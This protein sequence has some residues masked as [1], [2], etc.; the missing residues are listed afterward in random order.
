VND[1]A[2]RNDQF[3]HKLSVD[4]DNGA[5]GIVYY[6]TGTGADRKKT[7]VLFQAS[8]DGGK[9]WSK[10]VTVT[11]AGTD[12]TTA[13]ADNGNQYGDYNGLS[14]VK[15]VFFPCWTDRRDNKS[16]AIFTA[17]IGLNQ[18]ATGVEPKVLSVTG[19]N[20]P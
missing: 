15:G 2:G 9:T 5:L 10:P 13:S 12:E 14:V 4:P 1:D 3:N 18:G 19:G 16:E 6:G 7:N 17:K 11:T 20:V 8:S